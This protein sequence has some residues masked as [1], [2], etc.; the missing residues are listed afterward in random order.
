MLFDP[1]H[2]EH[3]G[4]LENQLR[5][6]QT[7]TPDLMS[8]M[9]A[10]ACERFAAHDADA[11]A[12]FNRL[13]DSGAW[14]D[15][16]LALIELELPRWKLRRLVYEDGEW[17]CSLSR[18]SRLPAGLDEAVE[19]THEDLPLAILI[20]FLEARRAQSMVSVPGS[21]TVPQVRPGQGIAICC[22]NFS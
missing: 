19:A 3:L 10:E 17:L 2:A 6:A 13:I 16:A 9:T 15:A 7:I 14:T 12:R 22:D 1:K 20:A 21:R 4:G 18:E 5:R 11:K 8:A